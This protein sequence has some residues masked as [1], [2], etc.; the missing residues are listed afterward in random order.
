MGVKFYSDGTIYF[1]PWAQGYQKTD[2]KGT[3]IRPDGS[4]YEGGHWAVCC[5]GSIDEG[6]DPCDMSFRFRILNAVVVVVVV[7]FRHLATGQKT[8]RGQTNLRG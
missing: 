7:V 3:W 1:G 6:P 8:W 5:V 2:V 4:Q